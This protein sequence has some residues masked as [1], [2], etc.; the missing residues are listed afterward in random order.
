[1]SAF[2]F[3]MVGILAY[4]AW[5]FS[6]SFGVGAIVAVVHDIL[7]TLSLLMF[8]GY[9]LSLNVVAA[10]LTITGYSVNDSI[11]VFDRVREN[12]RTLRREQFDSVVNTSVNQ[13]LVRTIITSGTTGFAALALF[14]FGGEVLQG[15]S[16]TILVGVF[17]GTY[18]TIFIAASVAIVITERKAER[19]RLQS[20]AVSSN[21]PQQGAKARRLNDK[22]ARSLQAKRSRRKAP[23]S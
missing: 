11:V 3:A 23:T 14:L 19:R 7:I 18:S 10:M 2:G 22:A 16:F 17:S 13:T 5:R 21:R 6:F 15:F 20:D 9:E 12:L 8:F 4:I 1:M